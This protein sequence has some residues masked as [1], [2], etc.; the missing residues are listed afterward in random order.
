MIAFLLQLALLISISRASQNKLPQVCNNSLDLC[1]RTYDSITHLGAHDSPFV[2]DASTGWTTF[3]NQYYN[4]TMQLD[5]GIRLLQ[6]Q[7]HMTTTEAGEQELHLCHS[8]CALSDMGRLSAW[9]TEIKTWMDRNP[10]DVVTLLLVNS[11]DVSADLLAQEYATAGLDKRSW[12][13]PKANS[14]PEGWPTLANL[15]TQGKPLV[16]FVAPLSHPDKVAAPYL[17]DEFAFL[18]ETPYENTDMYNMTCLPDRPAEVH[19][20]VTAAQKSQKLL[21]LNHILYW[22]QAFGIQVPDDRVINITNGPAGEGSLGLLLG[23]CKGM[24]GRQP[25]FVLVNFFDVGPAIE[26]VDAINNITSPI[27]RTSARDVVKSAR[28]S[29]AAAKDTEIRSTCPFTAIVT[30]AILLV[31]L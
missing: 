8:Y 18:Y 22:Q 15:L 17:L 27:G 31:I 7:V 6:A 26:N 3:G 5:A 20:N 13:P 9:L 29:S 19:A 1:D 28:L 25:T 16:S 4:S 23:R 2:R 11:D 21:V 24:Y 14:I 30:L 10:D 12:T